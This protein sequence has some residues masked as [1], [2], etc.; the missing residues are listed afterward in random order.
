MRAQLGVLLD[1]PIN[2]KL[3]GFPMNYG[4]NNVVA[5]PKVRL[6]ALRFPG[7]TPIEEHV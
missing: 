3:V 4:G 7:S 2:E 1:A 6:T 5:L